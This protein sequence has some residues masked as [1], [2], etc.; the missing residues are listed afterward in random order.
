MELAI[1]SK[2]Q[3]CSQIF[4]LKYYYCNHKGMAVHFILNLDSNPTCLVLCPIK[5]LRY[6][7]NLM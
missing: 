3:H 5:A 7:T 4:V 1:F 2:H 6:T